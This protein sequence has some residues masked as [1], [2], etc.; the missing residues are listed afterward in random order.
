ML[1]LNKQVIAGNLANDAVIRPAGT[2]R[3]V[4]SFKVITSETF[5][6]N[7]ERKEKSCPHNVVI[8]DK[9]GK[10]QD[11]LLVLKKGAGVYVEGRTENE[12]R[13]SQTT[14]NVYYNNQINAS[15]GKGRYQ[16]FSFV[17]PKPKND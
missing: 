17:T 11:K 4:L 10:L 2:G 9:E 13:Q 5:I 8:Y 3:E 6:S 7:G 14:G 12:R 1:N 16:I 15:K